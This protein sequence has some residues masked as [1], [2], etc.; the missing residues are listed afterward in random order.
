MLSEFSLKGYFF[1]GATL[2]LLNSIINRV[3]TNLLEI[4][5][6]LG[7]NFLVFLGTA[8]ILFLVITK[9]SFFQKE[10]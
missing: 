6:N 3:L 10:N 9:L 8:V 1:Y 5:L 7:V 4:E 2:I